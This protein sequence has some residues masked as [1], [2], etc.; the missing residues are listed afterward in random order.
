MPSF[1]FGI[2]NLNEICYNYNCINLY[3]VLYYLDCQRKV[4]TFMK[5][6]KMLQMILTSVMVVAF[7]A[8]QTKT[9]DISES[10]PISVSTQQTTESSIVEE[11]NAYSEYEELPAG[12]TSERI[13]NM[14]S[15]DGHQ[16]SFP[17]AVDDIL[18]LSDEFEL[19]DKHYL[20]ETEEVADLYYE[21]I[22]LGLIYYYDNG[23]VHGVFLNDYSSKTKT[24]NELIYIE[25]ISINDK[26]NI[27]KIMSSLMS[28][29]ILKEIA[30]EEYAIFIY[31]SNDVSIL[32]LSW[33]EQ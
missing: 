14:I 33:E 3:W 17:C 30:D 19:R 26:S 18:A 22:N 9:A 15:I 29:S 13:L 1:L 8:C 2:V 12:W 7:T 25:G 24:Y 16:L 10:E 27:E 31:Y 6:K 21:D 20:R 23:N 32:N 4:M 28:D 11:E 5:N